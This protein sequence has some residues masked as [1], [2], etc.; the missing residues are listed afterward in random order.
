M[1]E[2]CSLPYHSSKSD[3]KIASTKEENFPEETRLEKTM[4]YADAG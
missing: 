3:M 1:F 2:L 4:D